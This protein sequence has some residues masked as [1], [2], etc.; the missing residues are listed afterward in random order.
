MVEDQLLIWDHI[1]LQLLLNLLGPA[2]NVRSRGVKF[3][4]K[5]EYKV[6]PK[7]GKFFDVD[8]PTSYMFNLEF[9]NGSIVQGFISFDVQN[10]MRNHVELYGSNGS[11]IVPD[12]NMFGGPVITSKG[13][14]IRWIRT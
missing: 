7:K 14:R 12:P 4:D 9:H 10:H 8:I 6:G 1:F 5:R 2:K 11:I 13:V 3:S